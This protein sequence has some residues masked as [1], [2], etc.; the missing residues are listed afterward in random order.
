MNVREILAA[1]L[2]EHGYDG[3]YTE[4]CGCQIDGLCPCGEYDLGCEAGYLCRRSGYDI[5]I[6]PRKEDEA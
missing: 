5:W 6:G 1:W 4:D 3:L 2:R